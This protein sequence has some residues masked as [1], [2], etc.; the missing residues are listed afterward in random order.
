MPPRTL[1]LSCCCLV[2]AAMMTWIILHPSASNPSSVSARPPSV[3]AG[4]SDVFSTAARSPGAG[5][6]E[7]L[8]GPHTADTG[9]AADPAPAKNQKPS[10]AAAASVPLTDDFLKRIVA[11]DES[12]VSVELPGGGTAKGRVSSIQRDSNGLLLIQ[13]NVTHPE[14]GR[15][16]FQR[17]TAAGKAGAL[18]GFIHYDKCDVAYQIRPGAGTG[19]PALVKTTVDEVVCRAYATA[20]DPQEIPATHP[21]N[22]PIPPDEN[23]VIQL[24]SLPGATGVI[25]LD[26]DGEVRDFVSWGYIN[27]LPSNATNAQ[28]FEVWKGICEDFQPFNLNVTTVRA[29]YDAAPAGR[30][31]QV[32]ITPTSSAAPG[33]GGVA[34]V[35]SFNWTSDTVCWSFIT[36]GKNAIE[37]ISH[38]VGHTLGLSHDGSSSTEYY[39]GHNGWA[40]IMGVG[41]YQNLT[42]WSKGEYPNANRTEDD[43]SIIVSNNN[44]VDYR[45]DDHGATFVS[46]T[47]LEI[48]NTGAVSNEGAIETTE[49]EDSFRFST[50]GGVI[51]LNIGNVPYSPN[52][53]LKAEILNSGGGVVATHDPADSL[54]AVFSGLSLAAG[55]YFLRVSGVGKGDLTTGYSDYASLG[56]YTI[57]G[58]VGGGVYSDRFTVAENPAIGTVLGTSVPRASHGGG[59]L[60]FAIASGN[61]GGT[62]AIDPATGSLSVANVTLL[63]FEALSTRWDDPATF[64][65]FVSITDHLGTATE[66]IRTVVTVGDVNEAPVF[67]PPAA[68]T[69]PENLAAGVIVTTLEASDADRSDFVTY[70]IIDGNAGNAFAIDANTGALTS[71]G[72]LD[73]ETTPAF[74]LTLRATDHLSPSLTT[75]A[76]LAI[77]LLDLSESLIPGSV[78]RTFFNGIAGT[79]VASLTSSA[80]FPERPH[81]EA[82]LTSF[83]SGTAKGESYGSTVRGYVIAPATGNY[84]FWICTDDAGELRISPNTDPA[85][86]IVRASLSTWANPNEW[87]RSSTQQSSAVALTMGQAYYIEARHKEGGGG[88]HIQVA[89]QGPGMTAK[90]IIPGTWLAPYHQNY[91]PW[92]VSATSG[93]VRES[94]TAGRRAGQVTF[95]EPD[96]GQA[97]SSYTITGGNEAGI[98]AVSPGGEIT[99]A[100]SSGLVAGTTHSLTISATDSGTPAMVGTTT[101]NLQVLGL[102]EQVHTWWKL[103]ESSGA[104]V[105]DS[106]GNAR[107]ATLSG[108]GSWIARGPANQALQLDGATARFDYLGNSALSGD[109]SFSV[110][111]WVKVPVSH[112]SEGVLIQQRE[113]GTSGHIGRYVVKVNADGRINF[114]VYGR[115][116]NGVN[117]GT[118]FDITSSTAIKDGLWH[119]VACVRDGVTGRVFIDG[120]QLASGSGT[121]RLLDPTLTVAVGCDARDNITFLDAAVDDVRIY[122]DALGSQQFVRIAAIPKVTVSSPVADSAEIPGFGLVLHAQGSVA[123]GSSPAFAWS[124]V[125]GPGNVVFGTPA[126]G[127]TTAVFSA[128]GIYVLRVTASNGTDSTTDEVSVLAGS[129]TNSSFAGFTYGSGAAGGHAETEAN[130]YTLTGASTGMNQTGTSDGFYLLGQTFFGDF[131]LRARVTSLADIPGVNF[132]RAGLIIR[133]GTAITANGVSGFIGSGTGGKGHW[134]RRTSTGGGNSVSESSSMTLPRWCRL[135]RT[136]NLVEFWHSAD[137]LAWTSRGTMTFSGEVRAGL[138]WSSNSASTSG[139]ATFDNVSGFSTSN[140]GALVNAGADALVAVAEPFDLAGGADDDG[141]P[142]PPANTSVAW[143]VVSGPG[144]ATFGNAGQAATTVTCAAVGTYVLRL[145]A[146]DS[147]VQ[148]FDDI[149]LTATLINTIGVA[150]TDDAAAETG[151]DGGTF[152]FTRGG[153]LIG[154]LTVG[155]TLAGTAANGADYAA[156][157]N[158]IVIPGGVTT[159]TLTVTP[160]ADE[161]VEGAETAVLSIETGDYDIVD[162]TATVAIADS[163]HAPLWADSPLKWLECAENAAY[164]GPPLA[165]QATDPDGAPLTFVKTGGPDWLVVA[166]DGSLSGT[167]AAGDVGSNSFGVRVTDA[168]GLSAD[169]V[170]NILVNFVNQ[171]PEFIAVP[172]VAEDA[173]ALAPYTGQSLASSA[174]DPNL[175][176]GDVLAF[177]KLDGPAW[178][179]IAQDGSLSGTA[180]IANIGTN[181][182]FV[183]VSD[184]A[185]ATADMVL[186]ITVT[187]PL[188]FLDGNGAAAGSGGAVSLTWDSSAIWSAEAA[189]TTATLPWVGGAH[190]VLSAGNDATAMLVT[191][192]GTQSL[193][194]LTVEEGSPTLAGGALA[195][196][197]AATGFAITGTA[198]V[199]S[200][201]SGSGMGL[202]KS[203][204]GTLV[205]SGNNSYTGETAVSAGILCLTGSLPAGGGVIVATNGT[206]S[207]GG[208]I[209]SGVAVSGT[210][211]PGHGIGTLTT[212][213]LVMDTGARLEWQAGDWNEVAGTGYDSIIAA[214]LDLTDATAITVVLKA[215]SPANFSESPAAF[216]LVQTTAGIS[217]FD[218]G[219]FAIDATAFPGPTGSWEVRQSGNSLVLGYTPPTSF[220]VWQLTKFGMEAG[221]PLLAGDMADPDGDGRSNLMEYALGTD[222]NEAGP[223]NVVFDLE[224]VAGTDFLRLTINRNPDAADVTF[225]V[226]TTGDPSDPVTWTGADT[227][228]EENTPARLIV[229]DTVA[230]PRR[231]IRLRVTR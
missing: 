133:L 215:E 46:A 72:T 61:T 200:E 7:R 59:A 182:F 202:L 165:T 180:A 178:L 120:V 102:N 94:A 85:S 209:T 229:R 231:F 115:D 217:G 43:L 104:T 153:S 68:L 56:A 188:L 130:S 160:E 184:T 222:P 145:T 73:F 223:A 210:L 106:S 47:P 80:N 32:V 206:L 147:A 35:G 25:Y 143:S 129:T 64:E 221:N 52:L 6:D 169:A 65:L 132:E 219:K 135:A 71:A 142:N 123:D 99:V 90:E 195:L 198:E 197:R 41:Y 114:S 203:G 5:T 225:S 148:T 18:A 186:Q 20:Q 218:A 39:T 112:S 1:G 121:I 13:G 107:H 58:N 126:A 170:V 62:F 125:S 2:F 187:P 3:Q 134:V 44:D 12:A 103:D 69:I 194:S 45:P 19:K 149:S 127:S 152:T 31:I 9:R 192:A 167:P 140:L 119:H 208:S 174:T 110:F 48:T 74:T 137:G 230:G 36:T 92:V 105:R 70:S 118:Q 220:E 193:G 177:S 60:S 24:Q 84:T 179:A 82:T 40:S 144:S 122:A 95:L 75:D 96:L 207:G 139:S 205:L 176:Q 88:D 22:F 146:D 76:T 11:A 29:V 42:Q 212:G 131:D 155:F 226:Q 78:I 51:T 228:I 214:S 37:A 81:S 158:S 183:R 21:T 136:G 211:A 83:D 109:T 156:L 108:A 128:A 101:L 172:I 26:F 162:S 38:E 113:A 227:F 98:F 16:M 111:A 4:M 150:A 124:K 168:G 27:A 97:I 157:S 163:N 53:D 17:Q 28:I 10:P 151:P 117:E 204:P 8:L 14:A 116:A 189:G 164:A 87:T 154:D 190:A 196:S 66:L 161:L 138:C 23:G 34:Y 181:L 100:N 79:S 199:S 89:W 173:A 77:H 191:V 213:P 67:P 63:D 50:S 201:L 159:A 91:A 54:D 30:R 171:A 49:D 33:S 86:A 216:T 15:F 93:I 57:T 141:M 224:D 55:D 175:I 185:G 166:T